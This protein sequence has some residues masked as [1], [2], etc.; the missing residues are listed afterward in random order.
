MDTQAVTD[1]LTTRLIENIRQLD[2]EDKGLQELPTQML[3]HLAIIGVAETVTDA[4][5]LTCSG[6][7]LAALAKRV[8]I[9]RAEAQARSTN[10]FVLLSADT[11]DVIPITNRDD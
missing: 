7:D 5:D 9:V 6:E 2:E 3:Q 1:N 11:V 8:L 10:G 4:L